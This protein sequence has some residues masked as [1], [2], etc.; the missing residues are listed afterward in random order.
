MATLA[1]G[2]FWCLEAVYA[3]LAGIK[4]VKSGYTGGHTENPTYQEVCSGSTGHAEVVRIEYDPE[5][6][7]YRD[8]LGVFFSIH[9][10]TTKDRQGHDIGSQYRSA[11]YTHDDEQARVAR[12]AIADLEAEGVYPGTVVTE[13][14]EAGRFFP[15]EAYHDNYFAL[16]PE[17]GYC[18]AVIAPKVAKFRK[19]NLGRL[20]TVGAAG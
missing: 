13:V 9:D 6:I 8:L 3:E 19:H 17:Q 16:N 11:I 15:A 5:V 14:T 10:P 18:Q 4:R 12:E 1:G 20:R 7:S 2:C